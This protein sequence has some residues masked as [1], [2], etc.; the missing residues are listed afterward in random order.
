[1]IFP[2]EFDGFPFTKALTHSRFS[3]KKVTKYN[4][5]VYKYENFAIGTWAKVIIFNN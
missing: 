2:V 4:N 1:M 3:E 5:E